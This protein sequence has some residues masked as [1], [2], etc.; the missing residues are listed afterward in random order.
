[1]T[2]DV[3]ILFSDNYKVLNIIYE[4]QITILNETYCPLSQ[5]EMANHLSIARMTFNRYLQEL[6]DSG[7]IEHKSKEIRK[8]RLTDRGMQVMRIISKL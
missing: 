4:N 1:M 3:L 2:N 8:Y 6:I 7:L 5:I